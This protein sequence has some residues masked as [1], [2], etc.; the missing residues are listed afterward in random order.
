M[1]GEAYTLKQLVSLLPGSDDPAE[2]ER[3]ARQLR[4][5]TAMDLLTPTGEKHTGTGVS[6]RYSEH[7]ARKAA[8][9]LQMAYN[10]GMTMFQLLTPESRTNFL[11]PRSEE[12]D[13]Y[14]APVSA[15]VIN[16]TRLF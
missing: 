9:L 15:I 5:W 6:R 1:G 4:H 13:G 3:I 7:E 12:I 8:I 11:S 14:P 2:A 10:E 16:L